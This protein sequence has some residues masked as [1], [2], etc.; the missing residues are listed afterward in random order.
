MRSA[1]LSQNGFNPRLCFLMY[2]AAMTAYA[3]A[4]PLK[5]DVPTCG[6]SILSQ[7]P[8]LSF[9]LYGEQCKELG[10][11]EEVPL[12]GQG[13]IGVLR[14]RTEGAPK[15]PWNVQL[16]ALIASPVRKGDTLLAS[17]RMRCKASLAGEGFPEFEFE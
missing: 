1:A 4:D 13:E 15:V 2:V 7:R 16:Q 6:I 10:H 3:S 12:E 11:L 17:F 14:V 5:Q 9:A 8:L